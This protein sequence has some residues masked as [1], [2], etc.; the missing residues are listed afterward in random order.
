LTC[1]YY[2]YET[3]PI[4][5]PLSRWFHFRPH[6]FHQ[7]SVLWNHFIELIAPGSVFGPR[8]AR[9]IGGALLLSFQFILILSG[10][11]SFLNWLTIVPILACF[12]DSLLRRLLPG[13]WVTRASR[14][15][16]MALAPP[17]HN[18]AAAA[19]AI[20]VVCLSLQPVAN[21]ISPSQIM[22][23]SFNRL[24]LVNTYGAFGSVGTERREVVFEGASD[25]VITSLTKWSQYEFKGQPG[26]LRRRPCQV[27][28]YQL[29]LDWQMWFAAMSGPEEYPWTLNFVWKLLHN[30]AATLSLLA[31][32]PFPDKPPRY[33]RAVLYHYQFAPRGDA[34]GA[35]WQRTALGLWLPPLSADDPRLRQ[36]LEAHGWE[37]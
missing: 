1:L 35:W 11:L 8:L 31:S 36:W 21:L 24:H 17:A 9:H 20:V 23:T 27:A 30:D 7:F 25:P 16:E 19:L 10:N 13:T 32:N 3:Q 4:P 33:V 15:A 14:A 6:W 29:R 37:P 18:I 22:N 12:D 28:P 34:A 5:N 2:H 26:D